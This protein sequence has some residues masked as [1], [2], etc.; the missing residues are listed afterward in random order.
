MG[1]YADT[2]SSTT[3]GLQELLTSLGFYSG[4]ID[5]IWSAD[6]TAAMKALQAELGVPQTGVPDAATLQ[7]AYAH[8]LALG[9]D[10]HDGATGHDGRTGNDGA[11]GHDRAADDSAGDDRSA[12]DDDSTPGAT[13]DLFET[14]QANPDYS[15]FVD[16]LVAAGFSADTEVIGPFTIF[17]PTNEAFAKLP[18]GALDALKADPVKLEAALSYHIVEGHL[19]LP[20][21]TGNLTT[22]NGAVLVA[23]GTPPDVTVNGAKI[24]APDTVATNGVHPRNRHGAGSCAVVSGGGCPTG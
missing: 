17:A 12:G 5:G 19:L 6:V 8:G 2:L 24:V 14:L 7:A 1:P 18:A 16:L 4:P 10:R 22:I 23:T 3:L 20:Q 11:T 21:V 13:L 9:L 15:T